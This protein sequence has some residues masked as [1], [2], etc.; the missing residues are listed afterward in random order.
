[1]EHALDAADRAV[2]TSKSQIPHDQMGR[3]SS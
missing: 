2:E 1:M 3:R